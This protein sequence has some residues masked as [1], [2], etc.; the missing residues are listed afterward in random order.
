MLNKASNKLRKNYIHIRIMPNKA[1]NII[2]TS[3]KSNKTTNNTEY[4]RS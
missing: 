1:S 3:N 2:K 4:Y